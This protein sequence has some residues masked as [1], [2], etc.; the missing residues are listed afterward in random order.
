[1][2]TQN[3]MENYVCSN[4]SH[5]DIYGSNPESDNNVNHIDIATTTI[6]ENNTGGTNNNITS[7]SSTFKK[8]YKKNFLVK[9]KISNPDLE[10][11]I[12]KR[13]STYRM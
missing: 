6:T 7:E 4:S 10:F 9:N 5:N 13:I 8:S 11:F 12:K 3:L 1:M 2:S